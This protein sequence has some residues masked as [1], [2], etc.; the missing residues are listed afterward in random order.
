MNRYIPLFGLILVLVLLVAA[1][2]GEDPTPT[3]TP[4]QLPPLPTNTPAPTPTP[5]ATP[6]RVPPTPT[7]T[8]APTATATTQPT[9]EP[10]VMATA[11]D[12]ILLIVLG[13]QNASGQSGW[14]ALTA[15]GDQT[16]VVLNLSAG[17]L[18]TE[19]VHI[20]S[21]SCGDSL[22]GVVYSLTS[23]V[24][25]TGFSV[26]TVGATLSSLRTGDF[27][28]NTHQA[29]PLRRQPSTLAVATSPWKRMP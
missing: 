20:H 13:E 4:I 9:I 25:G 12:E 21:G 2:A 19:F 17:T 18:E 28:I 14:A 29:G 26:T 6:T 24:D 22:G 8:M 23:F 11:P 27:A 10:I 15:K 16:E 7:Q 3:Q 5:I 1:C